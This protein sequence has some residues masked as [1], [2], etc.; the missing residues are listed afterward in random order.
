MKLAR[1]DALNMYQ[2]LAALY[3]LSSA[4]T[5]TANRTHV[6]ISVKTNRELNPNG[7][8]IASLAIFR[9]LLV[10]SSTTHG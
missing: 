8:L 3:V 5:D 7:R 2:D 10:I 6:V 4:H 1:L 9:I